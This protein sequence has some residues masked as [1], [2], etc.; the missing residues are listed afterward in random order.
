MKPGKSID[1]SLL[2]VDVAE[3]LVREDFFGIQSAWKQN[4]AWLARGRAKAFF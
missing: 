3:V 1:C 4:R 2:S